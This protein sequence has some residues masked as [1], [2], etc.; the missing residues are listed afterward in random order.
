MHATLSKGGKDKSLHAIISN[1][2]P[3]LAFLTHLR[4][5]NRQSGEDVAPIFWD[6]NYVSL[7]PGEKREITARF[8]SSAATQGELN[9]AVDGWNLASSSIRIS[10]Q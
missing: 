9:L 5:V 3:R 10:S 2:S 6:D 8:D 1:P 4:V 7:L